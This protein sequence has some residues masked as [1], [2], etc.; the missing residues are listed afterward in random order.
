MAQL[1][2]RRL[3]RTER[4]VTTF[5][6]G[7]QASLQWTAEGVD[8]V[9]IIEKA[10]RSGVNYMDTSNI[11]GPSQNNY[12]KAFGRLGL[13]PA[14]ENYDRKAREALFVATKTHIRTARRPEGD[15]FRTDFSEGMVDGSGVSTAVDDVR[16][17][18]SLMFGDGRGGYP[19]EAYLDCVQLHNINSMDEVDMLFEGAVEPSPERPWMGAVAALLDL[20]EGENRTGCNPEKEK[21][22]RHIGITG[23]WNTAALIYAIQRDWQRIVDT[24][25]VTVNAADCR[26]LPHR[27]NAVATAAAAD[28]GVIGMKVFADAAYYHKSPHFSSTTADV[29]H[30][31]G[32]PELDSR[33]L[34]RYA[35]SVEG[36]SN[37]II[38]IGHVDEDPEKCQ[39]TQNISAAQMDAPLA[40]AEMGK[41]EERVVSAGKAGANAYFQRKAPGLTAPRNV[42]AEADSSMPALGRAAVRISWDAAYA[43][44][45]P[46]TRYD[47]LRNGT[48]I[49]SVGHRPQYSAERFHFDDVFDGEPEEGP[50]AYSVKAVDSQGREAESGT[51]SAAPL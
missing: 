4:A 50:F 20:R 13:S 26:Y 34:I 37:L 47:V 15:R 32:S 23:H 18:L 3:G 22:I 7:G 41:I 30:E 45:A 14:A 49:G 25:L 39:L 24:L 12:G 43:G 27:Y 8:P 38:G 10:W 42:G 48:V 29:Y 51:V 46:V 5:G 44:A 31:V 2:T 33:D 36:V 35:L 16:R 21:L 28:M 6:L 1:M 40:A 19:A 11:Y 9:A 17:S